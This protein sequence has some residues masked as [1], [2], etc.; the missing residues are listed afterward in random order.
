MSDIHFVSYS[1][2]SKIVVVLTLRVSLGTSILQGISILPW[3]NELIFLGKIEIPWKIGVPKL[4]LNFYVDI[5]I[6][7]DKLIHTYKTYIEC[8]MNSVIN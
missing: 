7:E 3:E 4:A 1:I 2:R 8:C 6:D 5:Q